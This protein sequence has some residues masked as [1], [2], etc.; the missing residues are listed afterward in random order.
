MNPN[1]NTLTI[2]PLGLSRDVPMATVE[3]A[4]YANQPDA[5]AAARA[6]IAE[7]SQPYVDPLTA[8][9]GLITDKAVLAQRL[10]GRSP[11]YI[12]AII[13]ARLPA[14]SKLPSRLRPIFV[15]VGI[16]SLTLLAFKAPVIISQLQYRNTPAAPINLPVAAVVAPVSADPTITIPK[17]TVNAPVVYLDSTREVDVLKGLESGIVHYGN[18][19]N[20]GQ[21]GNAVFFGHSSNDWW[22]PGNYKFVFV[23]LDKLTVGDKFSINYQAKSYTYQVTGTQVVEPTQVSV[24]NQTAEPTVTLITCS[25]PGTSW[26]R[27]VVSAKQIEPSPTASAEVVAKPTVNSSLP[28]NAPSFFDQVGQTVGG[29]WHSIKSLFGGD[30][31]TPAPAPGTPATIPAAN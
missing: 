29:V 10:Q 4:N 8:P 22:Q 14:R 6:R 26:K 27:L 16:F 30:T 25:P 31:S 3:R 13:P 19:P 12:P 28:G 1:D 24:L 9:A 17:I 2:R 21:G 15:A 11:V 7:L 5:A 18:T 20:P 23:L